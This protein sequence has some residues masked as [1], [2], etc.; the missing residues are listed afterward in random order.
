MKQ[1]QICLPHQQAEHPVWQL[2]LDVPEV[3]NLLHLAQ[4]P[5]LS[6]RHTVMFQFWDQISASSLP[7]MQ[8]TLNW[9]RDLPL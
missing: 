9:A 3:G 5:A 7:Y 6:N 2:H 4:C 8:E 1:G